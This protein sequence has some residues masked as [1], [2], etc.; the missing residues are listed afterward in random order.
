MT[1]KHLKRSFLQECV[2]REGGLGKA[3]FLGQRETWTGV[4]ALEGMAVKEKKEQLLEK[5]N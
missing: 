3:Q 2:T 1:I 5:E 4:V